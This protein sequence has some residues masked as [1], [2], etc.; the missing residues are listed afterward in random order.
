MSTKAIVFSVIGAILGVLALTWVAQGNEFFLLR[1]FGAPMEN[2]RY[3]AFKES[4]PYRDG[5]VSNLHNLQSQYVQADSDHNY[6][7]NI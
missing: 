4:Q 6:E 2:A 7:R 5:L 3:N 1:V